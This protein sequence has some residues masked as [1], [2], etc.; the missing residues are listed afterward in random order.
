[1]NFDKDTE[2]N[3][4]ELQIIEKNLQSLLM[5]KQSIQ[6]EFNETT[7]ALEEIK[8]SRGDVYKVLGGV[9]IKAIPEKLSKELGEKE[10]ILE[11]RIKSME[12]QEK[13]LEERAEKLKLDINQA[14]TK[15]V[16][17]KS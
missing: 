4:E 3:I 10:R 6:V 1:M 11:L 5:Q 17:Q 12:K 13:S 8:N 16:K 9:M 14:V 15:E 7:N 2:K